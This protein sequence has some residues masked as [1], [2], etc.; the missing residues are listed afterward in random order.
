MNGRFSRSYSCRESRGGVVVVTKKELLMEIL[1]SYDVPLYIIKYTV[2]FW[3]VIEVLFA[4][5]LCYATE[6]TLQKLSVPLKYDDCPV[7]IVTRMLNTMDKL[8]TYNLKIFLER[9][10]CGAPLE[11][12]GFENMRHFLSWVMFAKLFADLSEDDVDDIDGV[13]Y[14]IQR[15]LSHTFPS[16]FNP[17]ISHVCMTLQPLHYI[18]R[19][20]AIYLLLGIKNVFADM[21]LQALGYTRRRHRGVNYWYR[22]CPASAPQEHTPSVFFHGISTG[23]DNY[24][25]LVNHLSSDRAIFLFDLD[26][27]K[28]HSLN[29]VMPSPEVYADTVRQVLDKHAYTKVNL[30]GHSFGTITAAWFVKAHPAYVA[31]LTL[32]DPVSLLLH[33]PEVAFNFL[34]RP[35]GTIMEWAIYLAVSTEI[36]IAHALRRNFWWYKNNLWLEDLDPSIGVHVSLAGGDEVCNSV[37]VHEYVTLCN[38]QRQQQALR[39]ERSEGGLAEISVCYREGHSH[40]E[41][42]LCDVSLRKMAGNILG[43]QQRAYSAM[44]S[45]FQ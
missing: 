3:C 22:P 26:G 40:A 44:K 5:L 2:L 10:F 41:V 17:K 23:W 1:F 12:I 9:W 8:K 15:R 21:S 29:F 4:L 31:H 42:M 19:P 45:L 33:H 13:I 38:E 11:T 39:A 43:G 16:E 7:A 25:L 34:Y 6:T 27:V 28:S 14:D 32:I 30:V 35:P 37:T 36:T 18:H 20:L 24:L